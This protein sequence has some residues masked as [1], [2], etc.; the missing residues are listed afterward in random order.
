[1]T[2]GTLPP[3]GSEN[4]TVKMV[5]FEYLPLTPFRDTAHF[6]KIKTGYIDTGKL[7]LYHRDGVFDYQKPEIAIDLRCLFDQDVYWSYYTSMS[8]GSN[9]QLTTEDYF[10]QLKNYG[11]P[12]DQNTLDACIDN[13][14]HEQEVKE[15]V[16]QF[17]NLTVGG[18]SI[19]K[20][21]PTSF[22]LIPNDRVDWNNLNSTIQY[23]NQ[24]DAG[25]SGPYQ[26]D[27]YSIVM[28]TGMIQYSDLKTI[29]DIIC[30]DS[31]CNPSNLKPDLEVPININKDCFVDKDCSN[32]S[33]ACETGKC[34]LQRGY[35]DVDAQ[36][37]FSCDKTTHYCVGAN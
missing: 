21:L 3:Y 15:D 6:Q 12:V 28:L 33:L 25:I 7:S 31:N 4:A 5:N 34:T 26:N 27:N 11:Y 37:D 24:F 1:M 35:C 13:K 23:L 10:H 2:T 32:P 20:G 18:S 22:L 29:M 17:D 36:C 30:F 19:I 16:D 14:T 9:W 8:G